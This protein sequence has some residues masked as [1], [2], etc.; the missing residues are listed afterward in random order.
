MGK[1]RDLS[2]PLTHGISDT[3]TVSQAKR[4]WR[5]FS[6]KGRTCAKAQ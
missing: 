6:A 3:A 1:Y 4:G 2:V 5:K